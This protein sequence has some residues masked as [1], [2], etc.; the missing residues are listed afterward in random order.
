MLCI[1]DHLPEIYK[2]ENWEIKIN[3]QIGAVR[4]PPLHWTEMPDIVPSLRGLIK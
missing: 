4:E 3:N 2:G 1:E